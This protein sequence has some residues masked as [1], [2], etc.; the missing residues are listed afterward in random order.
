MSDSARGSA[1]GAPFVDYDAEVVEGL[2]DGLEIFAHD[3]AVGG[4]DSVGFFDGDDSSIGPCTFGDCV[5]RS[6]KIAEADVEVTAAG[7]NGPEKATFAQAA[8]VGGGEHYVQGDHVALHGEVGVLPGLEAVNGGVAGLGGWRDEVELLTG[9]VERGALGGSEGGG[10]SL[11]AGGCAR[12]SGEDEGRGE[13]CGECEGE[14][15]AWHEYQDKSANELVS[16]LASRGRGWSAVVPDGGSLF[17]EGPSA[18]GF[19]G[20][21]AELAEEIGFEGQGLVEGKVGSAANGFEA[22]GDG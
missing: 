9:G 10:C 3:G 6:G 2:D 18:F 22:G 11:S 4:G 20:A 1:G 17:E 16:K 12:A 13:R 21:S 15:E 14:A 8:G 7:S 5:E 19:V